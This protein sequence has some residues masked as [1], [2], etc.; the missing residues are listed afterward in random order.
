[1]P[2][3]VCFIYTVLRNKFGATASFQILDL[4]SACVLMSLVIQKHSDC[5]WA[6]EAGTEIG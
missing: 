1:M 5:R 4:S 6:E 3:I 2:L